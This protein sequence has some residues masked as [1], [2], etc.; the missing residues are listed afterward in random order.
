MEIPKRI[1]RPGIQPALF[2]KT[3][4]KLDHHERGGY[5][6]P[7]CRE[8]PEGDGGCAVVRGGG[9]P[10]GAKYGRNVEEQDI[11]KPHHA[12]QMLFRIGRSALRH[13]VMSSAGISASS[14]RKLRRNGSWER[15]SSA[16]VPKNETRPSCRNMT[17]SA[18]FLARCVSCVT[19]M[20]VLRNFDFNFKIR[21]L[22]W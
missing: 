11:P 9:D 12:R 21:L 8:N 22:M 15:S 10:A 16:H 6:K 5:E 3:G 1:F 17:R 19:T 4:R 13:A 2:R 18:S 20:E 7:Q 14:R